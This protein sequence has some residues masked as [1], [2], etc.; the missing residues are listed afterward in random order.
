MRLQCLSRRSVHLL[1]ISISTGS[2]TGAAV[3]VD[4]PAGLEGTPKK[5]AAASRMLQEKKRIVEMRYGHI[6]KCKNYSKCSKAR[7]HSAISSTKACRFSPAGSSTPAP[8]DCN[9]VKSFFI[10]K[11]FCCFLGI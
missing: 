11:H 6:R 8:N 2:N 5:V 4:T 9:K 7:Q 10:V 1:E 3:E